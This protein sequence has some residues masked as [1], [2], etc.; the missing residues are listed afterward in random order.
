[1]T[2]MWGPLRRARRIAGGAVATICGNVELTV[3]A[4]LGSLAAAWSVGCAPSAWMTAIASPSSDPTATGT[5]SC[6]RPC[7]AQAWSSCRSTSGT[8]KPSCSYA[9]D[10]AGVAVLF[11]GR[12]VGS[13]AD[14]VKHVFDLDDGYEQLLADSA[15]VDLPDDLPDETLA[16]LFYTG[17][18]TGRLE[19]RDA[20]PPQPRRQRLPL[21]GLRRVP[22]RHVL[23]DRGAAVPRRRLVA[24]LADGLASAVARSCC[25]C[26]I[27]AAALDLIE[28][29]GV[30]DTLVVPTMLAAMNE[31]QL[32][33]PRDVIEPAARSPTAGRRSPPRRSAERTGV[34]DPEF[35]A[36]PLRSDRDG[37][38]RRP[39]CVPNRTCSTPR[40]RARA[41]SL[42][43]ASSRV[44]GPDGWRLATGEVGEVVDPRRRT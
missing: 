7:R 14:G 12:D 24:V 37:A 44:I 19:G 35:L 30:T 22:A 25:R 42:R 36:A 20:H 6:T 39:P 29:H 3:R 9:L 15:P 13:A 28:R 41:V 27:A 43:S 2:T 21:P 32:A 31:E 40:G 33:R 34:P 16:G 8:A 17:G 10:D 38:D 26:S 1:M 5:S 18:T 4:D 11:A 23:A